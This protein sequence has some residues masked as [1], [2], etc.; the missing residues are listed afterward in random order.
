MAVARA[1]ASVPVP[2]RGSR[3]SHP[4]SAP[5]TV[6][7]STLCCGIVAWP[8]A[9]SASR[10]MRLPARPLLLSPYSLR[11][12]A[13][14][15]MANMS[16]PI[17]V[18]GGSTT[19]STAA[20][21]T[22]ASTALPPRAST[23]RPAAVARGWLVAI[24]PCGAYTVERCAS[25]VG[26]GGCCESAARVMVRSRVASVRWRVRGMLLVLGEALGDRV[27][28]VAGARAAAEIR[29]SHPRRQPLER[30]LPHLVGRHCVRLVAHRDARLAARRRPLE[31]RSDDPLDSLDG[32][33]LLRDVALAVDAALAEIDPFGVFPKD[34]EVYRAIRA[35]RGEAGVQQGNGPK[36]DVQVQPKAQSQQDVARVLVAWDARV[37]QCAEQDRLHV[38][39]Q[40]TERPVG[41][42]LLRSE[43]VVGRIGKSLEVEPKAVACCRALEHRQGCADHLRPDPVAG[44]H[45]D[46]MALH[47]KPVA[48][49]QP[50]Q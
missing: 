2:T 48:R 19:L 38:V 33:D 26:R 12:V 32:V 1:C 13:D 29:R 43:V 25:V 31:R 34:D 11:S 20:A 30:L 42:R 5:G 46:A 40:V 45:R 18:I 36:V 27:R 37:A 4:P 17:P 24:M 8:F 3:A 22:A 23:A 50:A 49:P 7:S 39:A 9:S 35:Q 47:S 28:D 44:D 6:T 16:P 14:H 10:V 21:V 15:T 41:K